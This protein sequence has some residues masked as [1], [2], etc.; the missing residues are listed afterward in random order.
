MATESLSKHLLPFV[1]D[2]KIN[3]SEIVRI[4]AQHIFHFFLLHLFGQLINGI[5]VIELLRA[6]NHNFITILARK[7]GI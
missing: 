7:P 2:K 1:E 3:F 5:R 6:S 4:F